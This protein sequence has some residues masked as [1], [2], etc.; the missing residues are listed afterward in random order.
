MLTLRGEHFYF[1]AKACCYTVSMHPPIPKQPEG[2]ATWRTRLASLRNI[3]P[4]LGM[5]WDTSPPLVSATA[6]LRLFRALL[7]V[8][9]LW[10]SKLILDGV[11]GWIR[12]GNGD[13]LR[14][15]KLVAL[16]LGLAVMSDLLGRANSL[17][18][19]LLGDR[20][21]NRIS[22]RLIEHATKLDLASF[23]DP[24]FYDKLERARRQTTGR[25]DLLAAILNV[26]QDGLSLISL[27]AGVDRLFALAD[28]FAGRRGDPGVPGRDAF[29]HH[30]LFGPV[31][32]DAAA[33]AAR[34]HPSAGR[35]QPER[36]RSQDL[37][38]GPAPG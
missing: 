25:L 17:F 18:D 24:V 8:A 34:L 14:I 12:R 30:G 37:R 1:A 23:E 10:V 4:L 27:S 26:A 6:V 31:S 13:S 28:G 3:R 36:Q 33:A 7:P 5:V 35:Q 2:E 9:M 29:H 32:L 20:F 16:E 22:V 19:S 21:T 38:P 15:W 11:V